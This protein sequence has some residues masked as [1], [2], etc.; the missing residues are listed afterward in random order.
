MAG[1]RWGKAPCIPDRNLFF[2]SIRVED[3]AGHK[4]LRKCNSRVPEWEGFRGAVYASG[5]R[6]ALMGCKSVH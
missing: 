5:F 4:Y 3:R 6:A 1:R 2:V